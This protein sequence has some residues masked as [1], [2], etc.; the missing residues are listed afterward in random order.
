MPHSPETAGKEPVNIN[1]DRLHDSGT[2]L[3]HKPR[4]DVPRVTEGHEAGKV[5]Q[6]S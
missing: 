2:M 3:F 4:L 5:M 6:L 1:A